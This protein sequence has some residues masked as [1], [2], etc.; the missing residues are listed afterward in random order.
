MTDFVKIATE[1]KAVADRRAPKSGWLSVRM[2]RYSGETDMRCKLYGGS[3]TIEAGKVFALLENDDDIVVLMD[4]RK[5][6]SVIS[7]AAYDKLME[8]STAIRKPK[9]K[10]SAKAPAKKPATSKA[11]N[12][13]RGI[14][15]QGQQ[16]DNSK[17][18]MMKLD[19]DEPVKK[20][21]ESP[22]IKSIKQDLETD[23]ITTPRKTVRAES[24]PT[25]SEDEKLLQRICVVCEGNVDNPDDITASEMVRDEAEKS[26]RS[27][28]WNKLT[29]KQ[30]VALVQKVKA[31]MVAEFKRDRARMIRAEVRMNR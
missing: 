12:P 31:K 8:N 15:K 21:V 5:T 4:G 7:Q 25:V 30:F 22:M 19:R 27:L 29:E 23:K 6:T 10:S 3:Y 28:D 2:R 18:P 17:R 1:L 26:N 11:K 14:P 24:K 13:L 16:P 20:K 9:A